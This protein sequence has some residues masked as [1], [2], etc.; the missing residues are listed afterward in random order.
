MRSPSANDKFSPC[1]PCLMQLRYLRLNLAEGPYNNMVYS[2]TPASIGASLAFW[3]H[4][5]GAG[6]CE[7][8]KKKCLTF[9]SSSWKLVAIILDIGICEW[10]MVLGTFFP[11]VWFQQE[12]LTNKRKSLEDCIK[13]AIEKIKLFENKKRGNNL[14]EWKAAVFAYTLILPSRV[15]CSPYRWLHRL[16]RNTLKDCFFAFPSPFLFPSFIVPL[17]S[18]FQLQGLLQPAILSLLPNLTLFFL[19]CVVKIIIQLEL[20]QLQSSQVK[21]F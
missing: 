17:F 9:R 8:P 6:R 18:F 21:I 1:L 7:M 2:W 19:R 5:C 20:L 11:D 4:P 16:H 12:N 10:A 15:Y 13:R 14:T 3:R